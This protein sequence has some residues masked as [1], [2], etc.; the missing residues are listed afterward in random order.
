VDFILNF[1]RV[2][3]EEVVTL[4]V[5]KKRQKIP[6]HK[7]L[8]CDRCEYFSKAFSGN[9]KEAEQGEMYLPEDEPE[10]VSSLI[11]Y[12]YRGALPA[13]DPKEDSGYKKLLELYFLAEKLCMNALMDKCC[14]AIRVR[15]RAKKS[16]P[17]SLLIRIVYLNTC[18]GSKLRSFCAGIIACG[19][20]K[21]MIS[22]VKGLRSYLALN[23]GCQDFFVDLFKWQLDHV[24]AVNEELSKNQNMSEAELLE[25]FGPCKFHSHGKDKKCYLKDTE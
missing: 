16:R 13:G 23:N 24:K 3:G 6:V 11:D 22:S 15:C 18:D 12:L 17:G 1:F 5:G 19:M 10:A 4:Y 2:L 9:F 25:I 7:K 8:I 20:I 14:D 21:G